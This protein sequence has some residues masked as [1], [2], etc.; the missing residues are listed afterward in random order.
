VTTSVLSPLGILVL[1][2]EPLKL[3]D[4]PGQVYSWLQDAGGFAA[5]GLLLYV[6][7]ML[8]SR[9]AAGEDTTR[10][11][12]LLPVVLFLG[13]LAALCY[14]TAAALYAV[15]WAN[16]APEVQQQPAVP[17]YGKKP[18]KPPTALETAA[19]HA[20]AAG[21]VF[22]LLGFGLPFAR[23]V[24]RLRFR[25]IWALARLSFKEAVRRRVLWVFLAFLLIFLFPPKWFFPIKPE[26]EIRTYVT[27][28]YWAMT[29]LL[30]VTFGLL[31]AF[32]IPNDIRSQ[33]IHTIVTKP[34]EKFEIV[35][36]RSLGYILLATLVLAV[37]SGASL[38]LVWASNPTP[39]A[40]EESFKARVP[41]YGDLRFVGGQGE[42]V[43]REWEYRRYIA[44]GPRSTQRAAWVYPD[45]AV[46][47]AMAQM[48]DVRCEFSFDIFRTTKGEE[49]KG[50]YITLTF[51][52]WPWGTDPLNPDPKTD[53]AYKDA[54]RGLNLN[55][56][57]G[58]PDWQ[59]LDEVAEKFGFYEYRSKEVVDYHTFHVNVPGGLLRAALNGEPPMLTPPGQAPVRQPRLIVLVKCESRTQYL[60]VAKHDLYLLAGENSFAVNFYKGAYGLWLR[61]CLVVIVAVAC[62]TYLSGVISFLVTIFLIIAGLFQ[63]FVQSLADGSSVGG[64]PAESFMRLMENKNLTIPLDQT[65]TA[66]R[67]QQSDVGFRRFLRRLL[68][69]IPDVDR[70]NW[71]N[72]VAGGFN[73]DGTDLVLSTILLIGYLLPWAVLGYYLMKSREIAS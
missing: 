20:V 9:V 33:T 36:G 4:V 67:A 48:P 29:L 13:G 46:P 6:V 73:I 15:D 42:S 16:R 31:A 59:R 44:G 34:V 72:Y 25:R 24:A 70:F 64:G 3:A 32:S 62:S 71:G 27:V 56:Q 11:S 53:Q 65:A 66:T 45:G 69:V 18:A 14:L 43:G 22:A 63:D 21:G 2:R 12:K 55:A 7:A 49:N 54:V 52:A 38:L 47:A 8:T 68:N 28:I 10:R 41:V 26:D 39:E 19:S 37:L 57:P 1:E 51:A 50:V 23:D 30:L 58:D 61:I 17:D 40:R 35:L 60:G 5:V